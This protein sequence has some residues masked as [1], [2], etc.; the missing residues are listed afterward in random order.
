MELAPNAAN[1]PVIGPLGPRFVAFQWHSYRS[2]LPPGAIE[3]ALPAADQVAEAEPQPPAQLA[4]PKTDI[5]QY[6][7]DRIRQDDGS[8]VT[9]LALYEEVLSDRLVGPDA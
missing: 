2:P 5:E 4:A 3:L 6:F 7:S 8:S 9:A 1:D